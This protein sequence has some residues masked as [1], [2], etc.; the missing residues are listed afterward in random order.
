[1]FF[2]P[3]PFNNT[4]ETVDEV[5]A[6][7]VLPEP[8]LYIMINGKPTKNNVL[9]RDL[10][11]VEDL[12]AAIEFLKKDNCLYKDLDD[13]AVDEAAKKVLEVANKTSSKMLDKATKQ[14]IDSFQAYT[15]RNLDSK[16]SNEPDVEEYKL[17]DIKE[18]PS[19]SR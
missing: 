15:I 5:I 2:L 9:W 18:D 11:D 4:V 7:K 3:L 1:M 17:L 14:D 8:E 10:V 12:K 6:S 19:D 13:S 16:L